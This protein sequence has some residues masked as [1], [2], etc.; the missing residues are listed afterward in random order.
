VGYYKTP[1]YQP[2]QYAKPCITKFTDMYI[3][4]LPSS[5][6][7]DY[8]GKLLGWVGQEAVGFLP[9]GGWYGIDN[10][11]IEIKVQDKDKHHWYTPGVVAG[12][13]D[14]ISN[15]VG[16][17]LPYEVLSITAL[18]NNVNIYTLIVNQNTTG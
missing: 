9:V 2:Y 1:P 6:S 5:Q 18:S 11:P 8:G 14:R 4:Q 7:F 17:R 15:E 16:I 13:G 12:S 3:R 10:A